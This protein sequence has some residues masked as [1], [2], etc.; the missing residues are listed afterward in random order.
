[1]LHWKQYFVSVDVAVV[2][3]SILANKPQ[4]TDVLQPGTLVVDASSVAAP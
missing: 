2:T 4:A 3:D 1:M